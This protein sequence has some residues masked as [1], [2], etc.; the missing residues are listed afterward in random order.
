M[1]F[2]EPGVSE[3][4]EADNSPDLLFSSEVA[5]EMQRFITIVAET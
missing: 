4:F 2:P 3:N 5:Q 1:F